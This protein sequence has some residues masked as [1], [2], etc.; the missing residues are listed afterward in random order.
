MVRHR[1]YCIFALFALLAAVVLS[2]CTLVEQEREPTLAPEPF[3]LS[4]GPKDGRP[5]VILSGPSQ[6]Q[7]GETAE[8]DLELNN[9]RDTEWLA[10]YCLTLLAPNGIVETIAHDVVR[11]DPSAGQSRPIAFHV[12]QDL[13][14]GRYALSLT[15]KERDGMRHS[16]TYIQV[17]PEGS[18]TQEI[19]KAVLER[20]AKDCP[21]FSD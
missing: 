14:P 7:P 16:L 10:S 20:A 12:S 13:K 8:L 15:V 2:S 5:Q 9:S 18:D 4:W 17:G 19:D 1:R 3:R 6:F 21:G 11:L